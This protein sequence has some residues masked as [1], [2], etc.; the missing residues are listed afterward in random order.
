MSEPVF[1]GLHALL[2]V[3]HDLVRRPRWRRSRPAAG[4][5]DRPLPLL[6]LVRVDGPNDILAA[7]S[8][9]FDEE[10]RVK[11]PHARVD[12]ETAR[13]AVEQRWEQVRKGA[14]PLLPLLDELRHQLSADRF[15][16]GRLSGFGH[17]R[18]VDWL[19]SRTV[20]PGTRKNERVDITDMLR[21]WHAAGERPAEAQ[22]MGVAEAAAAQP[23][24]MRLAVLL[25]A[26]WHRP[27][28][29]WLWSHRFPLIGRVPRWLMRQPFMLPGHSSS[30]TGFA[31]LLTAGRRTEEND[32]EIKKLLVHA[33]L[34]DLRRVYGTGPLQL[35][36][37][38]RTA[39]T[40]VL[41]ENITESN[42]GW[43]LLRLVNEVRNSSTRHD[44]VLFIAT[45]DAV[46]AWLGRAG[47]PPPVRQLPTELGAWQRT[48]PQSRLVQRED[49]RFIV[50]GL[51]GPDPQA[52]SDED[53]HGWYRQGRMV[54]AQVPVLARR[55]MIV[56]VVLVVLAAASAV[57]VPWLWTRLANDCLPSPS[58]GVAVEWLAGECVGYSDSDAQIFGANPRLRAAQA[59]IFEQ[60]AKALRVRDSN[61]DRPLVTVVYFGEFTNQEDVPN[62]AD[63]VTEELAGLLIRQSQDNSTISTTAPLLRVVVAN[64]GTEMRH[65]REV[66]DRLLGPLFDA[67]PSVMGVIGMGRTVIATE[68]A[69]GALG[70]RGIPVLATTLTGDGL[71]ERSPMYF[72][73]V[74]GNTAEVRLVLRYGAHTGRTVALY[75]PTA[76]PDSYLDSLE[77]QFIAQGG[78]P[79]EVVEWDGVSNV[80]IRC[81]DDQLAFYGGREGEFLGFLRRV[82]S[83]CAKHPPLVVGDDAVTRFVAQRGLRDQDDFAGVPLHYVS[84]GS[85]VVLAGPSCVAKG[86]PAGASSADSPARP[87]VALCGGL[88]RLYFQNSSPDPAWRAF[89]LALRPVEETTNQPW[90]SERTGIAYDAASLFVRLV[91]ANKN[92]ERIKPSPFAPNRAAIAQEFRELACTSEATPQGE[93]CFEGAGGPIDFSVHRDGSTRPIAILRIDDIKDFNSVPRCEYRMRGD[94]EETCGDPETSPGR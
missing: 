1:R 50:V 88:N 47:T 61:P 57:G 91:D 74:P 54:P 23:L 41:L 56:A 46:P 26:A 87:I 11:V 89:Q 24:W 15:G 18:F 13:V 93:P 71:A 84:L 9:R 53:T 31:E 85:E 3:V 32:A 90:P 80:N 76:G 94:L 35:R 65:A 77:A 66:V 17:Y 27:L 2:S 40:V 55:G 86:I 48:L 7:L 4:E 68:S 6:C 81:G 5:S 62:T 73:M 25:L 78:T 19:T 20:G 8:R 51:P 21:V 43:E 67:D 82:R 36:R 59:A 70:D 69:I 42:G 45:A 83:Q 72:Q 44:P 22:R 33:F 58:G 34:E 28:R 92:R 60:N 14:E 10:Q 52:A 63:A 37:W 16:T 39:Y 79:D 64:G 75:R 38:R 29:F 49:A 30:F 12:A